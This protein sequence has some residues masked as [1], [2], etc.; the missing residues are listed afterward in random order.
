[1]GCKTRHEGEVGMIKTKMPQLLPVVVGCQVGAV[2][3]G[4]ESIELS[5]WEASVLARLGIIGSSGLRS[6]TTSK[7]GAP[8]KNDDCDE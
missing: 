5:V 6:Y 3:G 1:M 2:P 7:S 4:R 8:E